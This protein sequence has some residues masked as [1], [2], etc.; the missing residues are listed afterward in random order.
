MRRQGRIESRP[1]CYQP[2]TGPVQSRPDQIRPDQTQ[3]NPD[4]TRS[5][6][7][8][9]GLAMKPDQVGQWDCTGKL[10][11]TEQ[12]R[13]GQD[14][15]V[16]YGMAGILNGVV[17]GEWMRCRPVA[18]PDGAC[19]ATFLLILPFGGA[20]GRG[21]AVG[22]P[23]PPQLGWPARPAQ[24][25][26]VQLRSTSTR[27]VFSI[28]Q[29]LATGLQRIHS[30]HHSGYQPTVALNTRTGPT[31]DRYNCWA[32]ASALRDF[33]HLRHLYLGQVPGL[34]Q[35]ETNPGLE[36]DPHE[37]S[38]GL[39]KGREHFDSPAVLGWGSSPAGLASG[40]GLRHMI[41]YTCV[42]AGTPAVRLW[43]PDSGGH[44]KAGATTGRMQDMFPICC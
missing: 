30:P 13:S 40:P 18:G 20:C 34:D 37:T 15:G 24:R 22:P 36:P 6:Q 31:F 5:D 12:D 11:R 10:Y 26:G 3:C 23:D 39:G 35:H 14:G 2:Q 29:G 16:W 19:D 8:R 42:A 4:W 7:T 32:G 44:W 28:A 33:R 41:C 9:P 38:P 21:R 25:G 43:Q 27:H 1:D 17:R